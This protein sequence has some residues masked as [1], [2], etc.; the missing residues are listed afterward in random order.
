ML[1]RTHQWFAARAAVSP[2]ASPFIRGAIANAF[3]DTM[4]AEPLLTQVVHAI[5]ASSDADEAYSA[6]AQLYI[7][8]GQYDTFQHLFRQW[9]E[10]FPQSSLVAS[11]RAHVETFLGWPNQVNGSRQRSRLRHDNTVSAPITINGVTD[12]FVLDTSAWQSAMTLA[13]ATRLHLPVSSNTHDATT[14]S[15][16]R[17]SS[18]IAIAKEVVLG[19]VHFGNV[20]FAIIEPSQDRMHDRTDAGIIGMPLLTHMVGVQWSN[21]GRLDFGPVPTASPPPASNL[22]FDRHH[23]RLVMRMQAQ[24]VLALLDTGARTTTLHTTIANALPDLMRSATVTFTIGPRPITLRTPLDISET[25]VTHDETCCQSGQD[26]LTQGEGFS[27]DFARMLLT[28][29]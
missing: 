18:R 4:Q 23:L 3:G 21:D 16:H 28:I 1:V 6:L 5:P 14:P 15:S 13:T 19:G 2:T 27:I 12:T 29:K 8:T 20:V 25:A 24:D 17:T 22:V 9:A 11:E 10:R 26:L 7:R